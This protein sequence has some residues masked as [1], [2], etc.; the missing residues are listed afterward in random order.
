MDLQ[1][2]SNIVA[3]SGA[4]PLPFYKYVIAGGSA[5]VMEIMCM[6]PTDLVKTRQQLAAGKGASIVQVFR[7]II[8]EEGFRNLYRGISSPLLA[9]APKRAIKFSSNEKYKQLFAGPNGEI[10]WYRKSAAGAAAGATECV[11]NTPFEVVKVRM[12]AKENLGRFTS[13]THCL[14]DLV[15]KE[16]LVGLY[17]GV[18]PQMWRNMVWNGIYFGMIGGLKEGVFK[19]TPEATTKDRLF[20][21]FLAGLVGGT[22]ATLGN[23]PFDV[24]KSRMQNQVVTPG[25]MPKYRW[26]LPSLATIVAEEGVAG[27]YKGLSSRLIRL[28]PGGGIMLVAFNT[29]SAWL[30]KF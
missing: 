13:T 26:T 29:I 6:Y 20:N 22:L 9:E 3:L 25:E 10:E 24:V 18:E 28:G 8:R 27:A 23:T 11:V 15:S 12:Q 16:G 7:D 5:G 17:K 30:A 19:P 4:A 21:D 14:Q 2:K 1:K